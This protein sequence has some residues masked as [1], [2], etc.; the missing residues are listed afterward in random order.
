[1]DSAAWRATAVALAAGWWAYVGRGMWFIW[2]EWAFWSQRLPT[3]RS[4]GLAAFL[5]DPYNGHLNG[6]LFA[7][8]AA[9][10]A[11]FGVG[12][13]WPYQAVAFAGHVL[14]ALAVERIARLVGASPGARMGLFVSV[15]SLGVGVGNLVLGWQLAWTAASACGA[16][17][18]AWSLERSPPGRELRRAVLVG[19]LLLLGLFFASPAVPWLL[20][21]VVSLLAARRHRVAAV[22]GATAATPYLAWFLMTS[23][24]ASDD[25]PPLAV[26]GYA[27]RGIGASASAWLGLGSS[28]L[29]G[30][31]VLALLVAVGLGA[32]R[33]RAGASPTTAA[34]VAILGSTVGAVAWWTLLA[35]NRATSA[36]LDPAAFAPTAPRYL[37]VGALLLAP[38]V[39]VAVTEA[40]SHAIARIALP[41]LLVLSIVSAGRIATTW[42]APYRA[43]GRELRAVVTELACTQGPDRDALPPAAGSLRPDMIA[44]LRDSG[45]LDCPPTDPPSRTGSRRR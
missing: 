14:T 43:M 5:L 21:T 24:A 15:L 1:M 38:V 20:A 28:P 2:D 7:V 26:A 12:A 22:A 42:V 16:W 39:A 32:V 35:L 40:M 45:R 29:V 11:V 23:P 19:S 8:W 10:D 33:R 36:A 6:G 18:F 31:L 34:S 25:A 37:H 4:D 3:F 13:Y 41:V 27:L 17:A 44:E 9:N 30:G